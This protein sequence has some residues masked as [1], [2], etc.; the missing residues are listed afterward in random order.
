MV[1]WVV[2]DLGRTYVTE[3]RNGVLTYRV[4]AEPAAGI[5]DVHSRPPH[6]DRRSSPARSISA[7]PSPTARCGVDGD[8]SVLGRLVGVLASMDRDFAIVTP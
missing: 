5:D 3:L 8:A 6:A 7:W 1:S 2:T 4:V